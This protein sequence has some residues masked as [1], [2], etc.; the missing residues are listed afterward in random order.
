MP[1]EERRQGRRRGGKERGE[2]II[3]NITGTVK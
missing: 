2:E 1:A 3:E